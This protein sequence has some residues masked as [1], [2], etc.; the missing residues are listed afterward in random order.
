MKGLRPLNFVCPQCGSKVLTVTQELWEA[1]KITGLQSEAELLGIQTDND[2]L[3]LKHGDMVDSDTI[4]T[5]GYDCN[6]CG[7]EIGNT[8]DKAIRWLEEHGMLGELDA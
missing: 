1:Y 8:E 3:Y 4:A 7:F 5:L 2:Y 6:Q